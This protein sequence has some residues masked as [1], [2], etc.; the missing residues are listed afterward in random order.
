MSKNSGKRSKKVTAKKKEIDKTKPYKIETSKKSKKNKTTEEETKVIKNGEVV[1]KGKKGKTKKHKVLKRVILTIFVILFILGIIAA[2]IVAGIFFSDKY[3]M[4][5]EDLTI[6]KMNSTVKDADGN[7]IATLAGEENRK[8]IGLEE[9]PTYLPKAFIAIE[10]KR[11]Y[12]HGAVDIGRTA[13][14]AVTYVLKG[15]KGAS[16]GGSTITQQLIKNLYDDDDRSGFA[17]IERKIREMARAY[18]LEKVASKDQILETYLNYIYFG[19]YK[20]GVD[21]M[22]VEVASEYYFSKSA[23][24]LTVA[25]AAFLA[26]INNTPNSYYPFDPEEDHTELIQTRTKTVIGELKNQG[27]ISEEEYTTAIAEVE[28]GLAFKKGNVSNASSYSYHTAAA[29]EQVIRD[30]MAEEEDLSYKA[31]RAR[32]YSNGYVIYTTQK[33]EIQNRMEEEY[34]KSKYIKSG[35]Q[36]DKEGNLI[37]NHTQ[38]AMV[39]IDHTTGQVVGTMGGL[40]TDVNALGLNRATQ[41]TKQTGSSMKPLASVAPG[42]EKGI[43]TAGTV[44]DDSLTDFGGGY[45]PHNSGSFHGLMTVR[46]GIEVSSNIVNLKI[47]RELGPDN[48]VSFLKK[49][50]IT[51]D[52]N[53]KPDITLALGTMNVSPLEMAAAYA[54]IANDGEYITPIFYT[55]VEDSSGNVVVEAKQEKTR[56]MSSA[57]AYIMKSILTSPVTG[58]GGTATT[59]RISGMDVGAKTGSTDNYV[60]RWLC[61]F[62]PYYTAA[63]WFG[64]D[65]SESPVFS[66]NQAANIWAAIM[67]DVHKSLPNKRFEKPSNVVSAKICLDSGCVATAS[68]SRTTTEYY[69]K[70]TLPDAC[71]GHKKLKICKDTGKIANEYCTNVEEKTFLVKPEKETKK[72]WTTSDGGKYDIPTETCTEHKKPEIEQVEMINVVGKK[73]ADAKKAIEDKGLKVAIKYETDKSKAD[74]IVLKQSTK[75][76]D[77]V[78]KGSTITITVNKKAD[79]SKNNTTGNN[80]AGGNTTNTNST[81]G[82]TQTNTNDDNT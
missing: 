34:A 9:M 14:A 77:K 31:A 74:G 6:N 78:D 51:I 1:K 52:S 28:A 24:D 22:G 7:V 45:K 27:Y 38:S 36:K 55:K 23:K 18:N 48:S 11:F 19:G 41:G 17:G 16:F 54:A 58:N 43:I 64:F 33:T 81:G 8:P 5:V 32:V 39:I 21:V 73:L 20:D 47:M 63:T 61:G 62:T 69:V 29:I 80:V 49:L 37:N 2:G 50:G 75:S 71:E 25:Q 46:E 82:S 40:G 79:D 3:K 44:Y 35:K 42:L 10:D 12:D 4:S 13:Y 70:G 68:C 67:K 30:L 65:T 76:G 56:V 66:G 60:D 57:N 53:Y 26:G 59:C 15:G 72:L